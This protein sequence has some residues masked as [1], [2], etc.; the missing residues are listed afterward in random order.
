MSRIMLQHCVSA[1]G[2]PLI[3]RTNLIWMPRF[4]RA[5]LSGFFMTSSPFFSH[6][7]DNFCMLS[8]TTLI[9]TY[10]RWR[11]RLNWRPST[12][13]S[14]RCSPLI[15]SR[16]QILVFISWTKQMFIESQPSTSF[17]LLY[18][19]ITLVIH[20]FIAEPPPRSN[21]KKFPKTRSLAYYSKSTDFL[22]LQRRYI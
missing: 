19:A 13:C 14:L 5:R 11:D 15:M 3:S 1:D 22:E 7:F 2:T 8:F 18:D 9:L 12:G 20:C 16:G 17:C 4:P 21:M 6:V 10:Y